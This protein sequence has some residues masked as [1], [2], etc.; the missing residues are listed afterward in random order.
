MYA[1]KCGDESKNKTKGISKSH[2]KNIKFE[3]KNIVFLEKNNNK[4]MKIIF[5]DQLFMR[6][7]F[8]KSKNRNYLFS[9]INV[10]I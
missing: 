6:R 3:E 10:V 8:K 5:Q 9:I 4:K 2:S 7:I 1:F